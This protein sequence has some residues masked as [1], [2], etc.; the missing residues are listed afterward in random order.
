M[1]RWMDMGAVSP[2]DLLCITVAVGIAYAAIA[3]RCLMVPAQRRST[4]ALQ[5]SRH[6][7]SR[8][9]VASPSATTPPQNVPPH[10][11]LVHRSN[12]QR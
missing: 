3:W 1:C 11:Y 4:M 5:P 12:P 7:V 8:V 10:L 6:T 9:V 2:F